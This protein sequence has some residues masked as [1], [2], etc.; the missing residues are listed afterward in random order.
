MRSLAAR[1]LLVLVL[2]ACARDPLP[3]ACPDLAPGD[4]VVNEIRPGQADASGQWSEIYNASGA[5]IALAGAEIQILKIDGSKTV[6]LLIRDHAVHVAAGDY[7][8]IGL[9]PTDTQPAFVGYSAYQDYKSEAGSE[10]LFPSAAIT[11]YGCGTGDGGARVLVDRMT[12]AA[13]PASG[14][15]AL[16]GAAAPDATTNDSA[17]AWCTPVTTPPAGTPGE[18]NPTCP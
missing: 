8:V 7:F 3:W 1:A 2:G 9:M 4:L 5:D 11:I 18:A 14:T 15:L 6:P 10:A 16:D 13:L 17:A 12:Y